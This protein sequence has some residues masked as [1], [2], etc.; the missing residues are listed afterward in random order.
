MACPQADAGDVP[1]SRSAMK[2]PMELLRHAMLSGWLAFVPMAL[3]VT[4]IGE[5][6]RAREV[7]ARTIP[8]R[9]RGEWARDASQCGL[10]PAIVENLTIGSRHIL[11]VPVVLVEPMVDP[12]RVKVWLRSADRSARE[13]V[14]EIKGEVLVLAGQDGTSVEAVNCSRLEPDLPSS[15]DNGWLRDEHSTQE[16]QGAG[17]RTP[18]G[19]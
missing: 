7:Q 18:N 9:Y 14:L 17:G 8:A 10:P 1:V 3:A 5:E 6:S 2:W 13:V 16:G 4:P 12:E 11:F 19:D 15:I